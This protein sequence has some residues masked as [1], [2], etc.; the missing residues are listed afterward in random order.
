MHAAPAPAQTAAELNRFE[1]VHGYG[2][3]LRKP[4]VPTATGL[5]CFADT[6][7]VARFADKWPEW[8]AAT[9]AGYPLGRIATA[10]EVAEAAVWMCTKAGFMT[11]QALVLDG[12]ASCS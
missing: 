3:G 2:H 10:E 4:V 12:G 5:L 7:M 11:G 9:N 8:Q 1:C 6:P